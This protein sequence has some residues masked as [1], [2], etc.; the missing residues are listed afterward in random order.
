MGTYRPLRLIFFIYDSVR[1]I[2]MTSILVVFIQP[3]SLH[4]GGVFPYMFY[5][6]PNSLFPLM[7]LFLWVNLGAYKPFIALYMAGKILAVVSVFAWLM[8]SLPLISAS[9][10]EGRRA[11]VI[12]A[13][14]ALF[15]SA[16]DALSVLGGAILKKHIL[17]AALPRK[18]ESALAQGPTGPGSGEAPEEGN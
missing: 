9:F 5:T 14:T 4:D 12:V 10:L 13:G 6:V 18:P 16:G 1:L 17:N 7:S 8:F 2:V 15:L 3:A 11:T